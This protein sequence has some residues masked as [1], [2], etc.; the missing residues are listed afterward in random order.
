MESVYGL[1]NK[2]TNE[3]NQEADKYGEDVKHLAEVT[4]CNKKFE[5]WIE[6]NEKKIKKKFEIGATMDEVHA[7]LGEMDNW[8]IKSDSMKKVLDDGLLPPTG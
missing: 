3:V 6:T 5:P 2:L 8:K 7:K 4:N 1:L